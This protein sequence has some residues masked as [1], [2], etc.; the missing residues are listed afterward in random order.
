MDTQLLGERMRTSDFS[1]AGKFA[2]IRR[3]FLF[4]AAA[5]VGFVLGTAAFAISNFLYPNPT[6][7]WLVGNAVG[8]LSHFAANYIL[9]GQSKNE[10]AKCFIV[11][12]ATGILAFFFASGMFAAAIILVK[13]STI[14]WL[15]G[16][17]IGTTT[18][19]VM[20]DRA[21]R[22]D[23]KIP[24]RKPECKTPQKK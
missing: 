9:Q 11:F 12:N 6:L 20:N 17:A 5:V 7:S 18:H 22:L 8:G 19:F 3:F 24:K 21:I 23:I 1:K 16:S 15:M 10:I 13:D 2:A 14:S 4:N